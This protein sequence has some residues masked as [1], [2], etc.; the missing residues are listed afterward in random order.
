M[1]TIIAIIA[2]A[3]AATAFDLIG[4]KVMSILE[5]RTAKTQP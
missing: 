2:V 4:V 3:L 1:G 5:N